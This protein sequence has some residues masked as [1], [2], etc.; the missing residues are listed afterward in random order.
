[1]TELLSSFGI[2]LLG[3]LILAAI[4]LPFVRMRRRVAH[5]E[6]ARLSGAGRRTSGNV[7]E[8][9]QDSQGWSITYEFLPYERCEKVQRTQSIEGIA[10]CPYQLGAQVEVAYEPFAPYH[11]V[12]LGTLSERKSV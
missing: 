10:N 11:S 1:V 9:W 4:A 5:D 6:A 7:T 8:T 2:Q 12:I 3:A